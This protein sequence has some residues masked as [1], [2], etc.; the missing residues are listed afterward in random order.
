MCER[1]GNK[2]TPRLDEIP[3]KTLKLP[4]MGRPEWFTSTFEPCMVV[5]VNEREISSAIATLKME[6]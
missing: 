3:N 6:G 4:A 1:T 2:K 5:R